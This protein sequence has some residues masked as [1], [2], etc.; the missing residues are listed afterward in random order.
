MKKTRGDYEYTSLPGVVLQGGEIWRC[1][2]C[3]FHLTLAGYGAERRQLVD[4]LTFMGFADSPRGLANSYAQRDRSKART[5]YRD[6]TWIKARFGW[7]PDEK[8]LPIVAFEAD[9]ALDELKLSTRPYFV[10]L[11]NEAGAGLEWEPPG[12]TINSLRPSE[13]CGR[14]SAA[15]ATMAKQAPRMGRLATG[16]AD[17]R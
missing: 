17:R 16:K 14:S 11:V 3:P 13:T 7:D 1:A 6:P 15:G 2:E 12:C 10:A 4:A 8:D 9:R 5:Q